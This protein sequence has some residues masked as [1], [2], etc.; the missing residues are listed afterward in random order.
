MEQP[1][2][3]STQEERALKYQKYLETI[4]RIYP[5]DTISIEEYTFF[6]GGRVGV[7]NEDCSKMYLLLSAEEIGIRERQIEKLTRGEELLDSDKLPPKP[8]TCFVVNTL[9]KTFSFTVADKE[10]NQGIGKKI[11]NSVPQILKKLDIEDADKYIIQ[12]AGNSYHPYL[13]HLK[14]LEMVDLTKKEFDANN[15]RNVLKQ[16]SQHPYQLKFREFNAIAEYAINSFIPINEIAEAINANGFNVAYS[17][18]DSNEETK[19]CR[20]FNITGIKP[21][22][23]HKNFID[24]KSFKVL[25]L[26]GELDKEDCSRE[27][28]AFQEY[29]KEEHQK[30]RNAG[31]SIPS[32]LEKYGELSYMILNYDDVGLLFKYVDPGLKK[33]IKRDAIA[34]FERMD[35]GHEKKLSASPDHDSIMILRVLRDSELLDVATYIEL[36][37]MALNRNY[38]L[39][40]F[41]VF[42]TRYCGLKIANEASKTISKDVYCPAPKG[43]WQLIRYGD[44]K[45]KIQRALIPPKIAKGKNREELKKYLHKEMKAVIKPVDKPIKTNMTIRKGTRGIRV[46]DLIT[47]MFG[48]FQKNKG[49]LNIQFDQGETYATFPP[50]TPKKVLEIVQEAFRR[51]EDPNYGGRE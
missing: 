30:R 9:D 47:W 3:N 35:P 25:S 50:Q 12:I 49:Y 14:S 11:Y 46:N 22:C 24:D 21:T 7:S 33:V 19:K 48:D 39:S 40:E 34:L 1:E 41:E 28:R 13:R 29:L 43:K 5:V 38:S 18:Y 31:E 27:F 2:H 37:Q 23:L 20:N 16:F 6:R 44:D 26:F 4:R 10:R 51:I 32:N 45:A 15:A 42:A 36:Y 17:L 8:M